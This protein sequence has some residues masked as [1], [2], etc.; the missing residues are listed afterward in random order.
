[1]L[2]AF[3]VFLGHKSIELNKSI[4]KGSNRHLLVRLGFGA[5]LGTEARVTVTRYL[6]IHGFR[7]HFHITISRTRNWDPN[8]TANIESHVIHTKSPLI[9]LSVLYFSFARAPLQYLLWSQAQ[10]GAA[11]CCAML[12]ITCCHIV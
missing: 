10:G 8:A 11:P 4:S 5:S 3:V 2:D 12:H 9:F 7:R 1:M 6:K